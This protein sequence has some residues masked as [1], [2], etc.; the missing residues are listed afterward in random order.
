MFYST[1]K[2]GYHVNECIVTSAGTKHN[3]NTTLKMSTQYMHRLQPVILKL[4]PVL[5]KSDTRSS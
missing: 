5:V 3:Y 2:T 4:W 1:V